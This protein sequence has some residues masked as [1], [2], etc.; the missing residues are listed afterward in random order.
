MEYP[1]GA[2]NSL[3]LQDCSYTEKKHKNQGRFAFIDKI[4]T[5]KQGKGLRVQ[6]PR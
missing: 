4:V 6:G 1:V 5:R 2:M 3:R